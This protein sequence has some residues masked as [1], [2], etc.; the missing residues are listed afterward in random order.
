MLFYFYFFFS[1]GYFIESEWECK[2][3]AAELG[4]DLVANP[5]KFHATDHWG[6]ANYPKGCRTSGSLFGTNG[7]PQVT[8]VWWNEWVD[9]YNTYNYPGNDDFVS[10]CSRSLPA[11]FVPAPPPTGG[12]GARSGTTGNDGCTNV[13][14]ACTTHRS[15]DGTCTKDSVTNSLDCVDN[16][17]N[18]NNNKPPSTQ[19]SSNSPSPNPSQG[20]SPSPQSTWSNSPSTESGE[21]TCLPSDTT[22]VTSNTGCIC[23]ETVLCVAPSFCWTDNSCNN[24][25]RQRKVFVLSLETALA[26]VKPSKFNSDAKMIQAFKSTVAQLFDGVGV[27][28][29]Y[30]VFA[31]TVGGGTD[32]GKRRRR[33]LA[34]A[35][36]SYKVKTN[37]KRQ[38]HDIQKN[39][40]TKNDDFTTVLKEKMVEENVVGIPMDTIEARTSS[41]IQV[42]EAPGAQIDSDIKQSKDGDLHDQTSE[43]GSS[44]KDT[45]DTSDGPE[46]EESFLSIPM[47]A[48]FFGVLVLGCC[49]ALCLTMKCRG[50]NSKHPYTKENEFTETE[51]VNVHN[52][53][54]AM[55]S[56]PMK[57]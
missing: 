45:S 27:A 20:S 44:S 34:D 12:S 39:I 8:Q 25:A 47:L 22:A 26:S 50:G 53:A 52:P 30:D 18:N 16:N 40:G 37:S 23:E 48:I 29:V 17:N 9:N 19:P 32:D 56:N 13:G 55:V 24:V 33:R 42:D 3:A 49:F 21:L 51:M 5:N 11:T 7:D 28:D 43:G 1:G 6:I 57:V 41:N 31:R 46:E 10:I 14:D 15:T 2:L 36:V 35:F 54:V 38:A 4:W